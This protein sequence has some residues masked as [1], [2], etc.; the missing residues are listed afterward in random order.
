MALRIR[1]KPELRNVVIGRSCREHGDGV[2][3]G[4]IGAIGKVLC[5]QTNGVT[6]VVETAIFSGQGDL[7]IGDMVLPKQLVG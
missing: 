4:K 6:A 3:M 1:V 2:K 5:F 7:P